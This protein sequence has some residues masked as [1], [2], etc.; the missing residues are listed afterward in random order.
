M[1]D[2]SLSSLSKGA[3]WF[4]DEHENTSVLEDGKALQELL[5]GRDVRSELWGH[6]GGGD[7]VSAGH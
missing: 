7:G 2:S 3:C 1:W 4:K 5:G 6:L